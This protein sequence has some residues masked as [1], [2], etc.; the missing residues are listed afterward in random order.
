MLA[1]ARFAVICAPRRVADAGATRYQES[2]RSIEE[3]D[4]RRAR[5]GRNQGSHRLDRGGRCD[6]QGRERRAG[7]QGIHRRRLR[8]RA[9]ARRR[10]RG[11]GRDRRRRGGRAAR[12]RAGLGARHPAAA[13]RGREDAA[14]GPR[15]RTRRRPDRSSVPHGAV[16]G[17]DRS[18]SRPPFTK[19]GRSR[20]APRRPRRRSP[21]SPRNRSMRIVDAMA[22]AATRR[23]PKRFARLAVE[24]TGY[25]VVADKVQKNLFAS[26][27]V[28]KFIRP[29][30]TVGVVRR[31]RGSQGHRDRRAVRRR[32]GDRAVDQPDVD[33]HLQDPDLAQGALP[34]RHQPAS[35]RRSAASRASPRSCPRRRARAGAPDGAINWMTTVTLEGTQELMKAPRDGGDP[36]DRRHG[37]RARR[38]QRRQAGLRRRPGQRAGVHRAHRRRRQGRPR[39]RHRQDVRQRRALL[40]ARTR[41]SSTRRSSTR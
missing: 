30:K 16:H 37:P 22:A 31:A 5:N 12:R 15:A 9:G 24:E 3:Q 7:R 17:P 29:M 19:R 20:G 26:E 27:Q 1:F 34:D 35:R 33:G 2:R 18:R 28:Y 14:Q 36:R 39:H 10:R 4:V 38:L 8:H 25:G 21:S 13:R 6:G 11:Q 41:S 32:R 40:V 23:R